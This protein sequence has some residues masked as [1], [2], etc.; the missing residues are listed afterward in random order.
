MHGNEY[1]NPAIYCGGLIDSLYIDAQE[2]AIDV[3]CTMCHV[4]NGYNT[5]LP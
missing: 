1:T 5:Y 2:R 4:T 3:K